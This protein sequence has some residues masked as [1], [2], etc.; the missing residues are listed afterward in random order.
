[1]FEPHCIFWKCF[2]F[3]K[4]RRRGSSRGIT[5]GLDGVTH[6]N[7]RGLGEIS[8]VSHFLKIECSDEFVCVCDLGFENVC[9]YVIKRER[10]GGRER[11]RA[12][13]A[14]V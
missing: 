12:K 9:V 6:G 11:K 5:R 10:E 3:R 1:M 7:A 4:R 13:S 14:R 2:R 8:C